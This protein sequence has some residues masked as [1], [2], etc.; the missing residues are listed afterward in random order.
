MWVALNLDEG[1]AATA[2]TRRELVQE[3]AWRHDSASTSVTKFAGSYEYRHEGDDR[4][5]TYSIYRNKPDACQRSWG[6]A[7]EKDAA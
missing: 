7:F 2:P 3:L 4:T 5:V 6:W 1:L